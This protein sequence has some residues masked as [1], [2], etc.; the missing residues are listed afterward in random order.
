MCYALRNQAVLGI[1]CARHRFLRFRQKR[2]PGVGP[3]TW[4]LPGEPPCREPQRIH[5]IKGEGALGERLTAAPLSLYFSA[6]L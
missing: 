3:E 5:I 4:P 2:Q 1:Y 6:P